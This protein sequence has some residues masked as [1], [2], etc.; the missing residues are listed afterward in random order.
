LNPA[1]FALLLRSRSLALRLLQFAL[2][3]LA[4][5]GFFS[6]FSLFGE[7]HYF[8]Q[9]HPFTVREI[10]LALTVL[11]L[12]AIPTQLFILPRALKTWGE[13]TAV[14]I[15]YLGL[16]LG[17]VLLAVPAPLYMPMAAMG[18]LGVMSSLLRPSL[19][20]IITQHVGQQQQGM[21]MGLVQSILSICQIVSPLYGGW[22][23]GRG[24]LVAWAFVAA[25]FTFVGWGVGF[26]LKKR[27]VR[28]DVWRTST[29]TTDVKY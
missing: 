25:G 7:R 22:L 6:G 10:G 14:A 12:A 3:S 19:V 1:A 23:I 16:S 18:L 24:H 17:F 11:G 8:Y 5:S 27:D 2:F 20:S 21:I 26:F 29:Q 15:G 4:F 9:G 28:Q 13:S